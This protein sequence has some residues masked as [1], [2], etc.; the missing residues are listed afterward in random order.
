MKQ[1]YLYVWMYVGMYEWM[2]GWTHQESGSLCAF[3]SERLQNELRLWMKAFLVHAMKTA[4][5][6]VRFLLCCNVQWLGTVNI[7]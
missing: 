1:K 5:C 7:G 2:Y 6:V 4:Q 3:L